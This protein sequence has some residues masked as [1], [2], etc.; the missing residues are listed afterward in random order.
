MFFEKDCTYHIYNR[1][2]ETVFHSR[3]NYLF[4][5]RKVRKHIL[6]FCDV[7]AYCLM[8]NHFHFLLKVNELGTLPFDKPSKQFVQRLSQ[9]FATLTSSYT[10]ALNIE[11][12]R[13]G[14]LFSH[15]TKAININDARNDYL[16]RSFIYIHQ[17]PVKDEIVSKLDE[18]EFSSYLDYVGKRN[19]TLPNVELGFDM[20]Q[21]DKNDIGFILNN[22]NR[23][24]GD[25]VF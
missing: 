17:N 20:L 10:Q 23:E 9:G 15:K 11:I 19:G 7:L 2:N 6:P 25:I 13:K 24:L 16:L 14:S 5:L 4:F 3:E 12:G 21:V 22:F 8:P 18:W 1:S